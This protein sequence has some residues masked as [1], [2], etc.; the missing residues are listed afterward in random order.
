MR[1]SL[2]LALLL[3]IL[4]P[5]SWANKADDYIKRG[6]EFVK[7]RQFESA[8]KEYN[9]ALKID[10]KNAEVHLLQGLTFA[11]MHKLDKAVEHTKKATQLNPGY[12]TFYQLGLIY[13]TKYDVEKALESFDR[14]L[15][16]S[17]ES[18]EAMYQKGLVYMTQKKYDQA[19][20]SFEKVTELN[21]Y[22]N[23]AYVTLGGA[24][25]HK[26]DKATALAQ[27]GRL[28]KMKQNEYADALEKWFQKK[29]LSA[30]KKE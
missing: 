27:A 19:I 10:S 16:Y 22:F 18:Y 4:P 25:Y 29:D 9:E 2:L 6:N 21:P 8:V 11:Q 28:R 12:V 1:N 3:I 24:Y 26:G 17:P 30:T 5:L 15:K 14:S 13:A 20:Q 23:E 7:D